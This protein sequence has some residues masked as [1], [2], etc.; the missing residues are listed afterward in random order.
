VSIVH[1]IC[2]LPGH[3]LGPEITAEAV[4]VLG[5]VGTKHGVTF[6]SEE[7]LLGGPKRRRTPAAA[8]TA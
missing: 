3:G 4:K 6:E 5:V 2:F 1:R 7:S 8:V